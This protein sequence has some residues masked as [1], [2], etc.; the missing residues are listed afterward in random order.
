MGLYSE[1]NSKE[2]IDLLENEAQALRTTKDESDFIDISA[3]MQKTLSM[4]IAENMMKARKNESLTRKE[5]QDST[6]RWLL[7]VLQVN[8]EDNSKEAH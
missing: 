7:T 4:L 6:N 8:Q 1:L 2:L 3:A 5:A